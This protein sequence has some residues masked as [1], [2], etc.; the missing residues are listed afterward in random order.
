MLVAWGR[1]NAKT[2]FAWSPF[3]SIPFKLQYPTYIRCAGVFIWLWAI[4]IICAVVFL[5]FRQPVTPGARLT[6]G[7]HGKS[8]RCL[9]VPTSAFTAL[10]ARNT[11]WA[12]GL[13]GPK[14]RWRGARSHTTY[15]RPSSRYS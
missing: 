10:V 12:Q 15:S 9:I 4:A 13:I 8:E 3:S 5:H 1:K 14:P 7:K 6:S 11:C 2:K